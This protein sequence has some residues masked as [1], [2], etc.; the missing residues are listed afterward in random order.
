MTAPRTVS[1][2]TL[3]VRLL[4]DLLAEGAEFVHSHELARRAR[5]TAAQVRRD[6]MVLGAPG[7]PKRGYK[8]RRLL[9]E[10]SLFFNHETSK[11]VALFGVGDL[12]RAL[13]SYFKMR[14]SDLEIVAAF[15]IDPLKNGRVIHGCR[16]YPLDKLESIVQE[17]GISVAIIAVP[18]SAA[19]LIVDRLMLAGIK[20]IVNF[21]PTPLHVGPA[22]FLE[23]L[24]VAMSL[25]KA[26]Y[27]ASKGM[28]KKKD[29]SL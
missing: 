13:L 24:D 21:A 1:R 20:G 22:V 4:N 12:G 17:R 15:D 8:C 6:L 14:H 25:E 3:Y 29:T 10:L 19:Q 7:S 28:P 9:D 11:P 2:L 18:A 26:A 23:N 16:C 5:V 27:F